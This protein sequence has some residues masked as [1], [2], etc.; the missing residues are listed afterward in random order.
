M[1]LNFTNA[2]QYH[3]GRFPPQTLEYARLMPELLAATDALAR[4]DQ[5]LKGMH[6]SEILLAPLRG[7]E[8]VVSSRI[9]GT[10][11]TLDEILQLEAEHGDD[12]EAA[13][14]FRSDAIET[15]LYQRAL[16][17]ARRRIEEGHPFSQALI[18]SIHQQLLSYGRGAAKAPGQ[19]K[20]AQNYI[21][22][23]G[24]RDISFVPI[25][26][27]LLTDGMERLFTLIA[28]DSLPILLRAA[29][30]HV[31]FEALHPFEDGNGRVG[32]MLITLMLWQGGAISAPHFYISRY[33]EEH[34]KAYIA[35]LRAV[36]AEDAWN[37]WCRFFLTAVQQQAIHNLE[38]AQSVRDC[39]EEMKHRFAELLASKYSVVALDYVFT[40]PIFRNSRFTRTSGIPEQTAARFS[41]L[42]LAEG[43][44]ETVVEASGRKSAV[45]RFEPLMRR[46]RM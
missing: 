44:L 38:L 28:D 2:A 17:T 5:M 23:R 1:N 39:Y 30:A 6:N 35:S 14:E 13:V 42:L 10:I 36:S 19:Y 12:L 26:P 46:V 33:F 32:R 29:L 21:G 41:R 3:L 24:S 43:L 37:D 40:N 45:Y 34:K 7:Q 27:E 31:E 9:E 11:S 8:A 15:A 20:Q 25:A 22:E 18:R 16:I 4:Y